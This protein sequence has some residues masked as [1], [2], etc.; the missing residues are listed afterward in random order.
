VADIAPIVGMGVT[1]SWWS[2]CRPGTIIDITHKGNRLII[3]EDTAIRIDN[4]G[5][6]ESQEYI[7]EYNLNGSIY[8]G[9]LRKDGY[10]RIAKS[11]CAITLGYRRKF[12]DYS[13]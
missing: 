1:I 12:H 5:M 7:Y 13:F 3:Q 6:S 4:N 8:V 10:Y 9:T 11:S 2:D